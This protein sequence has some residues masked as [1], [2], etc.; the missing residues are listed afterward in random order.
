MMPLNIRHN[1]PFLLVLLVVAALAAGGYLQSRQPDLPAIPELAV[2]D[3]SKPVQEQ[4]LAA[5]ARLLEA[6]L[7]AQRNRELGRILHAYKLLPA[8]IRCYR[9]AQLLAPDDFDTAYLLGIARLQAGDDDAATDS[10]RTALALD[11]DYA[12]VQ[13]RL[14]ELL[15]KTGEYAAARARFEALLALEPDSAWGH[16]RLAQ[17]LAALGDAEGAIVHNRRAVE[18][19]PD[20]GPAH[21][22]LALIYRDRG[23]SEAAQSHMARYRAA[24]EQTPPHDDALLAGLDDLDVSARAHVRRAKRLEDAGRLQE[25]LAALEAAAAAE[26]QSVE[27]HSQLVR[28]YHRLGDG[29]GAQRH[30][31]AVTAIDPNSLMANLEYGMLLAEQGRLAEA[32]TA[33]EQAL[34]ANPDHSTAHTLLAQARDELQQPAEAERHY[35]LALDSDPG[36]RRAALLLGRLLVVAKREAEAEPLLV[37]AGKVEPR[38]RAFYLQRIAQVWYEAGRRERAL[39]VLEDA[40]EQAA[41]LGQQQL[42]GGIEAMQT[43]WRETQ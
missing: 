26:P 25:A 33:F 42:L 22:A 18:L 37:Q 38:E 2:G 1:L 15:F 10:L 40:R 28:L 16:H 7:D 8:A 11:A 31:R 21:Y 17:T 12:P 27:A 43:Q 4:I 6:P 36:N 41:A 32:A 3:F 35:R 13:L 30:Y 23:D 20:F 29:E 5:R 19:F 39:A 24:P 9:R 14:G 34:A